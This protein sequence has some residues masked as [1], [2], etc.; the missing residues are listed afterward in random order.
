MVGNSEEFPVNAT[1]NFAYFYK[2]ANKT[3]NLDWLGTD[4]GG[5]RYYEY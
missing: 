3:I 2:P 5:I 4:E 1:G